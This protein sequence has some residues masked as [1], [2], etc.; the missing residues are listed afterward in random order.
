MTPSVGRAETEQKH[1]NAVPGRATPLQK[2]LTNTGMGHVSA[3]VFSRPPSLGVK[4]HPVAECVLTAEEQ[5]TPSALQLPAG[6]TS[7]TPPL[8]SQ[9]PDRELLDRCLCSLSLSFLPLGMIF[10]FILLFTNTRDGSSSEQC[11]LGQIQ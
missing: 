8:I 1:R 3:Q 10:N 7:Y 11:M 2:K 4:Q 9:D 6:S 5:Q